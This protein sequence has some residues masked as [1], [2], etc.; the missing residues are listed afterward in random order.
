MKTVRAFLFSVM[1]LAP[2][3]PLL[4]DVPDWENEEVTGINKEAPRASV[5]PASDKT[6]SLNGDWK[7]KIS[8][9]P[10]ERPADFF[11]P[12]YSVSGWDTVKVP[13]NWQLYGYGTAI[14]TN[15][16]YPFKPNPPKVM[17]E[18][19]KNWPAY[20]ERNSV[21]SYRR[22]FNL[23]VSWKG[24][25]V[26]IRFDGVESAFYVWVN[27]RQVGYSE[28]SYTGA[29]FDLTPYVRPGRNT[30]AVEVY[31][32]SDG[33]YLEDQDFLRLSGIFR[34]VTLFAQ[35]QT[36]VRDLFLKAGLD[37]EDYTTGVLDGTFTIRNSGKKDIPAGMKLNYSIDGISTK[38]NWEGRNGS[39]RVQTDNRG[40]LDSGTLEVPSIP[41]GGEV[42][43]SLNRKFPGVK[44]WTAET[45]NLYRVTYSLNGKDTRS[46]NIGFRSVE[47]ADN[48]AVLHPAEPRS[49]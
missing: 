22:D 21:G 4:G 37:R 40:R 14:Y 23:P 34:D 12:S 46:V 48:G 1:C 25:Q 41:S 8:M 29:E 24:E 35:P 26:M 45:P 49:P 6:L 19:P 27:G 17:G 44:P 9:T 28:D 42:Q 7:F 18:P 20:R 47:I 5:F 11:N 38:L 39:G 2:A 3:L 10:D 13:S 43:I 16:P 32:W 33:S 31:R 36:H 15:V 30:I